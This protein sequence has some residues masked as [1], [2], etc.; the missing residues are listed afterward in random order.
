[1]KFAKRLAK[2]ALD[3]LGLEYKQD[4]LYYKTQLPVEMTSEEKDLF[5]YIK[6]NKLSITYDRGLIATLMA[7]RYVAERGI[8]GDF[9][10]CGVWRGGNAILAASLFR[11]Y[12]VTKK[13]VLFDTFQGMTAP[14]EVDKSAA[15][16][17]PA[18]EIFNQL[19]RETHNEMCYASFDDVVTNFKAVD[20]LDDNVVFVRGDVLETLRDPSNLPES[21]SILRLDTDWYESTKAELEV[22]YPRLTRGG[23]LIVDDYGY[24]TG[25]KKATDEYFS[26]SAT[27]PFLQYV[28]FTGRMAVKFD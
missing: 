7:C 12:G 21:I 18:S 15:T 9:V 3:W 24:W 2:P 27:R 23:V 1:M 5:Q 6:R 10:E 26:E 13:V 8:T 28:D 25:A 20:L 14:T 4:N 11:L 17:K 22:L 19:Q 16:N